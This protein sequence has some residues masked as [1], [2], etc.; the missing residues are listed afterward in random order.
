MHSTNLFNKVYYLF[1]CV[2]VKELKAALISILKSTMGKMKMT[3]CNVKAVAHSGSAVSRL[4]GLVWPK[5]GTDL[6]RGGMENGKFYRVFIRRSSS[7]IWDFPE[8]LTWE[9]DELLLLNRANMDFYRSAAL[10]FTET[11][12]GEHISD[13]TLHLPGAQPLR[14]D[15]VTELRNGGNSLGRLPYMSCWTSSHFWCT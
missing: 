15:H 6:C 2:L 3:I 9:M 8:T 1:L 14:A 4:F 7:F 10:C 13:S 5:W 11:W 12:L